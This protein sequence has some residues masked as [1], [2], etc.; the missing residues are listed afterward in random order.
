MIEWKDTKP[1]KCGPSC[2]GD[3]NSMINF[4][5]ILFYLQISIIIKVCLNWEF[6]VKQN[7]LF[8][9]SISSFFMPILFKLMIDLYN[10]PVFISNK[11]H[12]KQKDM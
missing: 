8:L 10:S 1:M 6:W 9:H 4:L 3:C 5:W 7:D 11:D 2:K 12:L